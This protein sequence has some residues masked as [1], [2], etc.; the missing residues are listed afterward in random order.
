MREG[1]ALR[2]LEA[3]VLEPYKAWPKA[4]RCCVYSSVSSTARSITAAAGTTS[5]MRS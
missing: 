3:R 1:G 5:S 4:L 2:Q